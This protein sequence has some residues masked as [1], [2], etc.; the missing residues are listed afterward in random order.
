MTDGSGEQIIG[1]N[2]QIAEWR[3]APLQKCS[4]LHDA[5]ER[6]G[7]NSDVVSLC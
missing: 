6:I 7:P 3:T 2:E 4:A 1:A 5:A